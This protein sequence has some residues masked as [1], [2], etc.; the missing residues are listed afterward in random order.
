MVNRMMVR[1]DI[2]RIASLHALSILDTSPQRMFDRVTS[3]VSSLL[4]SS[5]AMI[6]LIDEDRQWFL[7]RV[8]LQATETPRN[9]AFCNHVIANEEPLFIADASEDP[10]F[11]DNPLVM[12][13]PSIR[14]Y[15]GFPVKSPDGAYIGTLCAA[16]QRSHHFSQAHLSILEVLAHV[17]E[18]LIQSYDQAVRSKALV[19]SLASQNRAL[20]KSNR[21]FVQAEHSAGIGSWEIDLE[22]QELTWSDGVYKIH[23]LDVGQELS[24]ENA[25]GCYTPLSRKLVEEAL[26]EAI[27]TKQTYSVQADLVHN[28]GS[29]VRI[30]ASGE[31]LAGDG[32]E[33]DRM[34]GVIQDITESHHAKIALQRAADHDSLTGMYN[35]N[36]FDRKLSATLKKQRDN[37]GN[38]ALLLI[39]LDG[40][41]AINDIFGHLVGDT[42]LEEISARL[43]GALTPDAIAARWGGDEFAIITPLGTSESDVRDLGQLLI[44]EINHTFEISGRKLAVSATIGVACTDKET[45]GK[46]LVRRADLAMYHGKKREPGRVHFYN[47]SIEQSNL[48]KQEAVLAVRD[49]IEDGRLYAAYQPIVDLSDQSLVALEALMRLQTKAGKELTATNVL[50]AILDPVISRDIGEAMATF[51]ANDL[52]AIKY[53]QPELD[54]ISLNATEADLLSHNFAQTLLETFT[55]AGVDPKQITLEVTE[56]MLMVND[57]ATVQGVLQVLSNAGMKIALDDFGTGFSSLSHLRDFPI[58]LVKIDGSFVRAICSDHQTRLIVQ[59]LIGMAKSLNI[60]VIAEGIEREDQLTLLRQMGC[61]FGQGYLFSPAQTACRYTIASKPRKIANS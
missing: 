13:G 39:D 15:M 43:L 14:S 1:D 32:I 20:E 8:G 37:G 50:P 44:E 36:A 11:S 9:V 60:E 22:T 58:D 12:G 26:L 33:P 48:D 46:E 19:N 56:T 25:I 6:S 35:R 28:D 18:D 29:T 2:D 21:I 55:K 40:F 47:S 31:Y 59:A 42:V 10:R 7:S 53:A 24:I 3:L 34:V 61:Q 45:G 54:Y 30:T 4:D 17:V 38:V 5:M 49:A 23:G 51:I 41:K 52:P 16:D 27:G 57:G